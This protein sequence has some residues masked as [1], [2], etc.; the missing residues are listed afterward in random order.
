[1]KITL[2]GILLLSLLS[3]SKQVELGSKAKNKT[4]K[5]K[6]KYS[7]EINIKGSLAAAKSLIAENGLKLVKA[8]TL[9]AESEIHWIKVGGN[10]EGSELVEK[11]NSLSDIDFAERN[12]ELRINNTPKDKYWLSQWALS[13]IGQDSPSGAS[14][15]KGADISAL[16]A[17]EI[18]KGSKN[19]V[20]GVIDTGIDY[21]HP[22]LISN[23]WINEKEKNG[24][25]GVDD[26]GNGYTDD[27]FGWDF[28]SASRSETYYGQTGDADPMDDNDHGTHCAGIIGAQPGNIKGIAGVN[29]KVSLMALK[30]LDKNG[31]GSSKDA[32]KAIMYGANN[33][34]HILSNSWGGGSSSRLVDYAVKYAKEKGVLFVAA[35][36]NDSSNNDEV[37]NF[38]SNYDQENMLAVL[39]SDVKDIPAT[40]TNYGYKKV[41]IAAPGVSILSTVTTFKESNRANPYK[42]FSGTSMATPYVAGVAA[43]VLAHESS[44]IGKPVELKKRLLSTVDIK[45]A[46]SGKVSSRG[47]INAYRALMNEVNSAENE[48]IATKELLVSSPR[49]HTEVIDK[50]WDFVEKGAKKVRVNFSKILIDHGYDVLAVYDKDYNLIYKF[51]ADYP[52]LI[53]SPWVEGDTIRVRFANALVRNYDWSNNSYS[54][55]FANFESEGISIQSLDFIK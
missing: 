6:S 5:T 46:L 20:V 42:V 31:S 39:A 19:I 50:T 53:S 13:N 55:N 44:L 51:D 12:I 24:L 52:F 11:L 40:F 23:M 47:R 25:K 41:H 38:P 10:I 16:K 3:C 30:F 34:A 45:P 21:K 8:E 9:D 1:M 4:K 29:W 26:D 7:N 48:T 32:Y 22:D 43:L 27:I 17:W 14:G 15:T 36:G 35:A 28:V 2:I 49:F 37:E 18:T 54:E 33:G